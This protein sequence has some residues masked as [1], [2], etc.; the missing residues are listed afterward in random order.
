MSDSS[1][2]YQEAIDNALQS[3]ETASSVLRECEF[4]GPNGKAA[5]CSKM[6][7]VIALLD[8]EPLE[9]G[10]SPEI[11]EINGVI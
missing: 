2:T 10:I 4:S 11:L 9:I 1:I 7:L 5:A 3:L 8:E 6:G